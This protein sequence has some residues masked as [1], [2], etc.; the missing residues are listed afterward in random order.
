[1]GKKVEKESMEVKKKGRNLITT[2]DVNPTSTLE[3]EL[4]A[5][6]K[7]VYKLEVEHYCKAGVWKVMMRKSQMGVASHIPT[8]WII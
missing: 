6:S 3:K 8:R 7:G 1:M 5:F 4:K 2:F